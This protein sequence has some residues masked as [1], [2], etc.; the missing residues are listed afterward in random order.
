MKTL[1]PLPFAALL[2]MSTFLSACDQSILEPAA[3]NTGPA[4][5][6]VKI[7]HPHRGVAHRFL[8]LPAEVHPLYQVT[9]YTKVAGYLDT[10]TVDKGDAVKQGDLIANID[11]PE[12]QV[13]KV[14][15]E[16]ELELATANL[17]LLEG[18]PKAGPAADDAN[19]NLVIGRAKL[20]VAKA[21]VKNT[22]TMLN[23]ARIT[24]PFDGIVTKRY[25]DPG[26]FIPAPNAADT[27][28]AAAIVNL[29]DFATLRIQIPVPET[30]VPHI[31]IGQAVVMTTDNLPGKRF[32]G[33]VTR[34]YHA[35]DRHT[36]T[37]LTEIQMPNPSLELRPGMLMSARIDIQ[38]KHD[39]LLLPASALVREKTNTFV[40]TAVN[41]KAK[42]VPVKV[43]F[44]DGPGVEIVSG[45]AEGDEVLAGQQGLQDGEAVVTGGTS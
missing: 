22:E 40:F 13:E 12:L 7:V 27:P 30:E 8:T 14:K 42:K 24:A 19:R 23:Y 41:G 16:A 34:Y 20:N 2:C 21:N 1:S 10:L 45:V 36:K 17:Q 35:L 9:L 18:A 15:Y 32:E 26:A 39:V 6:T 43:G 5:R 31:S 33:T 3:A 38:Q 4:P 28:Q 44:S 25:V 29:S 37:M 11:V